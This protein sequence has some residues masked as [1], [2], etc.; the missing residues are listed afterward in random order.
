M[1]FHQNSTIFFRDNVYENEI[2]EMV[3]ILSRAQCFKKYIFALLMQ[4]T[5][6]KIKY[7][8]FLRHLRNESVI[9]TPWWV[10]TLAD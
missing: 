1:L 5:T 6:T 9:M 3:A 8:R 7:S 2:W 4:S 10:L